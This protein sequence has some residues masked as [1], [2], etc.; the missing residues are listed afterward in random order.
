MEIVIPLLISA[1]VCG[2][3][4]DAKG[5]NGI[6]WFALGFLLPII[7]L[8]AL[9]AIPDLSGERKEADARKWQAR[10]AA[11]DFRPCP[12]CAEPIRREARKCRFC[13]S[14]VVPAPAE[15]RQHGP[16]KPLEPPR[17]ERL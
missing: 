10:T 2:F 12:D 15:Q 17:A 5:R 14:W 3:V 13:G 8:L 9:I 4:A 7:S 16:G 1:F 11:Q 6:G